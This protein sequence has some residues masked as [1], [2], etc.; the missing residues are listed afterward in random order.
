[1]ERYRYKDGSFFFS[2]TR[3]GCSVGS[4]YP[5]L[6]HSLGEK[7]CFIKTFLFFPPCTFINLPFGVLHHLI[8]IIRCFCQGKCREVIRWRID[9]F[10]KRERKLS[11]FCI[12]LQLKNLIKAAFLFV[13]FLYSVKYSVSYESLRW[14]I[15]QR[16]YVW[17]ANVVFIFCTRALAPNYLQYGMPLITLLIDYSHRRL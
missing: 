12:N 9:F 1:M 13:C 7:T 10:S 6:R 15:G 16:T 8:K 11:L 14:I 3:I 2:R 4:F 17:V 5:S